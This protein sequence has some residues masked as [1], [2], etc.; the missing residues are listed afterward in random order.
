MQCKAVFAF[1]TMVLTGCSSTPL[2]PSYQTV[3]IPENDIAELRARFDSLGN[4]R[5]IRSF[6]YEGITISNERCDKFFDDL[7]QYKKRSDFALRELAA[8]S[9]ALPPLLKVAEV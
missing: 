4:R 8:L 1:I 2:S 9:T 6:V 7:D 3:S 5:E